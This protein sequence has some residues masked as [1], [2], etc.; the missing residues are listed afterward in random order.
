MSRRLR[1]AV[2]GIGAGS[3]GILL[4]LSVLDMPGF[5]T[6]RHPYRDHSVPAAVAHA[7]ANVVASVNFDQRGLDTLVEESILLASVLAVA[8]VLR[9][10]KDE[11][12]KPVAAQGPVLGSTVLAGWVLLPITLLLGLDVIAN[13][14]LTPGGGFQGGVIVGTGVHLLYVAG[15]Y[16]MFD[17]VRPDRPFEWGEAIGTGAFA[18]VGIAGVVAGLAFLQNVI[19]TGEL[20]SLFSAGTV[21]LLNGAVGIG[22]ASAVVVLLAKFLEQVHSFEKE[23][24]AREHPAS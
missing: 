6:S 23:G 13:G 9:R 7:T 14:H 17:R 11:E 5:G 1:F 15:T 22:V 3:L 12:L 8:A 10:E 20:G 19:P 16:R 2:F 18:C 4:V 21:P 24:R